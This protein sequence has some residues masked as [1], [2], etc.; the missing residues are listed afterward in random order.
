MRVYVIKTLDLPVCSPAVSF[1]IAVDHKVQKPKCL[2]LSV[3]FRQCACAACFVKSSGSF[4]HCVNYVV[5]TWHLYFTKKKRWIKNKLLIN[6][7]ILL[8]LSNF[9]D[10][11][12]NAC[13]TKLVENSV[14]VCVLGNMDTL[15]LCLCLTVV[16][17]SW[18]RSFSSVRGN[19]QILSC[20][21]FICSAEISASVCSSSYLH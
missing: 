12:L 17:E 10:G 14:F 19:L 4:I 13:W 6:N 3:L 16:E 18:T 8:K 5:Y 15:N 21:C 11:P 20:V 1:H 7:Q 9:W 2:V